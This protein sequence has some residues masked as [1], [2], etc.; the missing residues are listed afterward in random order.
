MRSFWILFKANFIH[1]YKLNSFKRKY[2]DKGIVLRILIPSLLVLFAMF[3]IAMVG[4]YIFSIGLM[5]VSAGDTSLIL[6]FGITI[7]LGICLI[8]TISRA[9]AILFES[10]DYDMLMSLPLDTK[11]IISEK[12]ANLLLI[13]YLSFGLFYLP[14]IVIY[15]IYANPGVL[16]YLIALLVFIIAPLLIITICSFLSYLLGRLLAKFKYKNLIKNIGMILFFLAIMSFNLLSG[17]TGEY[18]ENPEEL[19]K[20]VESFRNTLSKIFYINTWA[21]NALNGNYI[22]LL[23]YVAI[24]VIPA[25][26]FVYYVSKQFVNANANSRVAYTNKNYKFT[27]QDINKPTMALFKK[28]IK[29]YFS[30]VVVVMNTIV[31][32]IIGT[33]FTVSFVFG[34]D[35][36]NLEGLGMVED[37]LINVMIICLIGTFTSS[38]ITTSA[39]LISLEGKNFWILK[40]SPISETSIFKAKILMSTVLAVP[41]TLINAIIS[42]IFV[43]NNILTI[44]P[45]LLIPTLMNLFMSTIGLYINLVYP[46]LDWNNETQVVK[47]GMSVM[48]AMV[49]GMVFGAG[50]IALSIYLLRFGF[51]LMFSGVII[52]LLILLGISVLIISKDGIKRYRN[53]KG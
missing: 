20:F 29:R 17:K 11:V 37:P 35:L 36:I 23:K 27:E 19:S 2:A 48:I 50:L 52:L 25:I 4:L 8:T 34:G 6:L 31:G 53:I 32:P 12:I 15:A 51:I 28:E 24:S 16:F 5:F 44:I 18:I 21:E 42:L 43:N 9:N 26:L 1:T 40:S 7:G 13:N 14:T 41:F 45:L 39:S 30:S 46:R 33:I 47:Q 49:I 3:I 22:D 10:K 38:M